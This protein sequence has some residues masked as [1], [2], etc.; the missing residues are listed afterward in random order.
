MQGVVMVLS[1]IDA[2]AYVVYSIVSATYLGKLWCAL[3]LSIKIKR[4]WVGRN[5]CVTS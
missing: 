1:G 4:L 3:L 2:A 5:Y